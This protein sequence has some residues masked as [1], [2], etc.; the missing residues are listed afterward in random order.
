MNAKV[1]VLIA[2]PSA[3]HPECCLRKGAGPLEPACV[4][5]ALGRMAGE[6]NIAQMQFVLYNPPCSPDEVL[7]SRLCA[8]AVL[9]RPVFD[10][11]VSLLSTVGTLC[12]HDV[13]SM[14][15]CRTCT[16]GA[17]VGSN[18]S[19]SA[20]MEH[21]DVSGTEWRCEFPLGCSLEVNIQTWLHMLSFES[22]LAVTNSISAA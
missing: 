14:F 11:I 13:R 10:C 1:S 8:S 22:L 15:G 6:G 4:R 17:C 7:W 3:V 18:N 5:Q 21:P 16:C 19:L 12:P 20:P 9:S 2:A